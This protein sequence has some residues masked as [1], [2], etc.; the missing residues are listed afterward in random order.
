MNRLVFIKIL[1]ETF[2]LFL[3][4]N[5][6][7]VVTEERREEYEKIIDT[8]SVPICMDDTMKAYFEVDFLCYLFEHVPYFLVSTVL[9]DYEKNM[10]LLFYKT[11]K[12]SKVDMIVSCLRDMSSNY[13]RRVNSEICKHISDLLEF[14]LLYSEEEL[15]QKDLVQEQV[16][17]LKRN[18]WD[19]N[20]LFGFM[21]AE[22]GFYEQQTIFTE[23][24]STSEKVS[25]SNYANAKKIED[26]YLKLVQKLDSMQGYN[27][28]KK[29]IKDFCKEQSEIEATLMKKNGNCTTSKS[30]KRLDTDFDKINRHIAVYLPCLQKKIR[31]NFKQ[32]EILKEIDMMEQ[33]AEE[34]KEIDMV[35]QQEEH[36]MVEQ[37]AENNDIRLLFQV[38]NWY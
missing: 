5:A 31:N 12:K 9:E 37:Q 29:Y 33:Q 15:K 11:S 38:E 22:E 23:K 36:S 35:E 17:M 24:K 13:N 34:L 4:H 30:K 8:F 1:K 25:E 21:L 6:E 2:K 14:Y 19:P 20:T 7:I 16:F 27:D 28:F 10:Y 26:G 3:K 18:L 32:A